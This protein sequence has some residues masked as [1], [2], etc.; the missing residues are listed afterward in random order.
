MVSDRLP[1]AA[2]LKVIRM[3]VPTCEEELSIALNSGD[4]SDSHTYEFKRGLG[5]TSGARAET[6][7]LCCRA[8]QCR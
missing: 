2:Q 3:W 4:L 8:I 7:S 6:A 5:G 1:E